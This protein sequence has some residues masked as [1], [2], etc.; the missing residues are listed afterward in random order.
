MR[1]QD[2]ILNVMGKTLIWAY[3]HKLLILIETSEDTERQRTY[4]KT[5]VVVLFGLIMLFIF[6]PTQ[7]ILTPLESLLKVNLL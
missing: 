6:N 5:V 7:T 2:R 1:I 4:N 3:E